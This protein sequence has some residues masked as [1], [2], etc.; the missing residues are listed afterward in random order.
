MKRKISFRLSKSRSRI[1]ENVRSRIRSGSFWFN[2]FRIVLFLLAVGVVAVLVLFVWYSKDLPSPTK[3]VRRDGYS[4]KVYDR[5][6]NA[7]FDIYND[8]K[9]E[10]VV[11]EDIPDYLKKATVSVEDK[12]FYTHSGIDLLTPF[13][14]IKNLFYFGKVTG[15]ST[16]TQQLTRNVLLT[17]ERSLN[18][19]IK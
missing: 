9:R 6:G 3:V 11:A 4:S 8:A 5:N 19:K 1:K 18:R 12:S 10:P 17:T 7:L 16:L 15:G 13:R 14:I 2:F